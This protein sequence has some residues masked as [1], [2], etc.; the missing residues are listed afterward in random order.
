MENRKHFYI[1][2]FSNASQKVHP[3][4]TLSDF[5]IQLA[6]PIDLGSAENWEVG[7]CEFNC[8][9]LATGRIKPVE[10]VG[11]TNALIY[12]DLITP[13]FVGNDYVRC[14]RTLIH[15]SLHCDHTFKTVYYVPVE[16]RTFHDISI[17]ITNLKGMNIKY[18]SGNV[19]V[20]VVLHFRRV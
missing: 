5:K 2:L 8:P 10:V 20:K 3:S 1:T 12:C 13:Q 6:Q 11:D 7:L 18:P 17:L 9:P 4:N 14:L 15:P 19:P 16:K